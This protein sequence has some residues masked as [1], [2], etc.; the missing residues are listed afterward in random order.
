[1]KALLKI[2]LLLIPLLLIGCRRGPSSSTSSEKIT[3]DTQQQTSGITSTGNP[4]VPTTTKTVKLSTS[5]ASFGTEFPAGTQF[6][7]T[8]QKEQNS[9]LVKYLNSSCA[10][11]DLISSI[12]CESCTSQFEYKKDSSGSTSHLTFGTQKSIGSFKLNLNYFIK[13]IKVNAQ[14]YFSYYEDYQN[15][16]SYIYNVDVG[17][18][19]K[20]ESQ[21]F[22]LEA[23][24]GKPTVPTD[25]TYVLDIMDK[26][27]A[28]GN[29]EAESHRV[30]INSIEITYYA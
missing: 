3:T 7:S 1:M 10:Q 9:K 12:D 13:E 30:F 8:E 19:L 16:G 22:E 14:A 24:A 5:G 6:S 20:I 28:L 15:P 25:K 27:I 17:A 23:E 4:S 21:E 11:N 2:N 18:K 26:S 29:A